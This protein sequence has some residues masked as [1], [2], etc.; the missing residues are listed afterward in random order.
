MRSIVMRK[1]SM[2]LL[3]AGILP[4]SG[5]HA[6]GSLQGLEMDVMEADESPSQA[7]A[8]IAL[9]GASPMVKEGKAD[10]A[11]L[12]TGAQAG[13]NGG[14]A[15][16]LEDAT[17]MVP[18]ATVDSAHNLGAETSDNLD[19]GAPDVAHGGSEIVDGGGFAEEPIEPGVV[20]GSSG[21]GGIIEP[22]EGPIDDVPVEEPPVDGEPI[23]IP[24]GELP[25]DDTPVDEPPGDGIPIDDV[26]GDPTGGGGVVGDPGDD[27]GVDGDAAG[28]GEIEPMP[29]EV[30]G[31][32]GEESASSA[33][34]DRS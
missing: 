18:E 32:T 4:V 30:P 14:Q 28:G 13:F 27:G 15:P 6:D 5:V 10:D 20:D 26:D 25:G 7:T 3:L 1:L 31:D 22:V 24:I 29:M 11:D 17:A 21:D 33:R 34:A 23:E 12:V 19:S 8:R 2:F 9:P 16:A